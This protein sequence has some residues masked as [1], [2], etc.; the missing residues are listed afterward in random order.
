M[1]YI[2]Q[3]LLLTTIVMPVF[4]DPTPIQLIIDNHADPMAGPQ[5]A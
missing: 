3:Y 4:G 2:K 5:S 1:M